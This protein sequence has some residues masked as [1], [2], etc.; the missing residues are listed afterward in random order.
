M[1]RRQLG[2]IQFEL[3][4]CS[5]LDEL[6][7]QLVLSAVTQEVGLHLLNLLQLASALR[8]GA[9]L[10]CLLALILNGQRH[11]QLLLLLR[12]VGRLLMAQHI[13]LRSF[14]LQ[15]LPALL[16]HIG[17]QQAGVERLNLV[18]VAV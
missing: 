16:Q 7:V 9:R 3:L 13:R 15:L 5:L 12:E 10:L 8:H 6:P 1:L 17:E 2:L 18:G 11:R 14:N 4:L